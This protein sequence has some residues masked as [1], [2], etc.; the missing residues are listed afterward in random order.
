MGERTTISVRSERKTH[1]DELKPDGVSADL[2]LKTLLEAYESEGSTVTNEDL[3]TAIRS[4]PEDTA[5]ELHDSR[6]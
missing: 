6:F 3:L 4:V 5:R 2:F 1:F